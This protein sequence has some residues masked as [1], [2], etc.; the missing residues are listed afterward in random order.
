LLKLKKLNL[1]KIFTK[2]D[3]THHRE[4]SP[5]RKKLEGAKS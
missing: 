1:E 3:G 5:L 2:F 4:V